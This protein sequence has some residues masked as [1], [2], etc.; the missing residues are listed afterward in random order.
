MS[1]E[2]D[3]EGI[4]W[5]MDED[6]DQAKVVRKSKN[7]P[8]NYRVLLVAFRLFRVSFQMCLQTPRLKR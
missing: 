1:L 6:D 8:D 4:L 7:F 2:E 3:H 5:L